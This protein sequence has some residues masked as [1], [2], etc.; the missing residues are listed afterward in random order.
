MLKPLLCAAVALACL[1][2]AC[3]RNDAV[4]YNN[5]GGAYAGLN[6]YQ[7]AIADYDQALRLDP[8]DAATYYNRGGAY[9]VM[10]NRA[11]AYQDLRRACALG[12]QPACDWLTENPAP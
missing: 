4:A 5:R 11:R 9:G 8:N 7:R 3:A 2:A 6:Q 1:V 12:S 10:G